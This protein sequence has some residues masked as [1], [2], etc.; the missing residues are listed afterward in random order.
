MSKNIIDKII[1]IKE[2]IFMYISGEIN[3]TYAD[4]I[5]DVITLLKKNGEFGTQIYSEKLTPQ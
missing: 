5:Q 2:E 1:G 4:Y 3:Y